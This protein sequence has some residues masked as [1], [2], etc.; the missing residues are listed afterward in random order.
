MLADRPTI[1]GVT[2]APRLVGLFCYFSAGM[3]DPY[4]ERIYDRL[5]TPGM[6]S[7]RGALI[8][9]SDKHGYRS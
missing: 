2:H 1:I 8:V 9:A 7:S 4:A 3:T 6:G 5:F